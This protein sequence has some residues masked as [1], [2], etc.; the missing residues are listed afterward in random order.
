MARSL[1]RPQLGAAICQGVAIV[2]AS[3]L[4]WMGF[5][6]WVL[7]LAASLPWA[8]WVF[9]KCG[10]L[11]AMGT[12]LVAN[13]WILL[14]V[15][16]LAPA[17][18]LPLMST[19]LLAWSAG[20]LAGVVVF[21]R[22][23]TTN[24]MLG[25]EVS[26]GSGIARSAWIP[27]CLGSVVVVVAMVVS[28]IRDSGFRFSWVMAGDTANNILFAREVIEAGG[29]RVGADENPVPLPSALMA[30]MMSS[31][32]GSVH[33]SKLIEHDLAAFSQLWGLLIALLCLLVGT[34]V[35]AIAR[36][37]LSNPIALGAIAATASLLP[38]SWLFTG[39]ALEFGFFGSHLALV[40]LFA[41]LLIFLGSPSHPVIAVGVLAAAATLLLA[42]WSPLVLM[43]LCLG[44]V[45]VV[46]SCRKLIA[47]RGPA[48]VLLVGAVAQFVAYGL[49]VVLPG[50]LFLGSFLAAPGGI[51]RLPLVLI[52]GLPLVAVV[53][54]G[55]L[56]RSISR[57]KVTTVAWGA[58]AIVTASALGLAVLLFVSRDQPS[59]WT[60]YPSKFA[61]TS[62]LLVLVLVAG[63][64]PAAAA[65]LFRASLSAWV[66]PTALLV[67]V[68]AVLVWAPGYPDGV[69]RT[70]PLAR[71]AGGEPFAPRDG[72][73]TAEKILELAD[74]TAAHLMWESS[75]E[76]QATINFW[77][78]QLWAN[79][80]KENPELRVLA[81]QIIAEGT[82][83]FE[84]SN[85][86]C[87]LI[88]LMGGEVTIVTSNTELEAELGESCPSPGV[89]VI[90]E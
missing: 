65:R 20:G 46:R 66:G 23:L 51:V 11:V 6:V 72:S 43:P 45:V 50:L 61:W 81:Y 39:F 58:F 19:V 78:I 52:V 67:L 44:L 42:V 27:A 17:L 18:P 21:A 53:L 63:L 15:V 8:W 87:E 62:S 10:A 16:M 14:A 12:T 30:V 74:P 7:W 25:A 69:A 73:S 32:R 41:S 26:R 31:G 79:S 38:L 3:A 64:V 2:A 47:S 37:S 77:L 88:E 85:S 34:L 59:P 13:L 33:A 49:A 5:P 76:D 24:E 4:T 40:I 71:L 70:V 56:F 35:A 22:A 89:T 48:M 60:Y 1:S 80:L 55:F 83:S 86:P 68:S 36:T 84:E 54:A 57:S 28:V 82:H 29:V 90:L 9:R 75:R